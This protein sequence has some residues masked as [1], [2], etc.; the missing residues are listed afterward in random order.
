MSKSKPSKKLLSVALVAT[1]LVVFWFA[2]SPVRSGNAKD[3]ATKAA[4]VH[5]SDP[6]K[7][8]GMM[9]VAMTLKPS[10]DIAVQLAEWQLEG[11]DPDGALTSLKKVSSQSD[12]YWFTRAKVLIDLGQ[13]DAAQAILL[14]RKGEDFK[15]LQAITKSPASLVKAKNL[16]NLH[17]YHAAEK[18]LNESKLNT[19]GTILL[20]EIRLKLGKDLDDLIVKLKEAIANDPSDIR[21]HELLGEVYK[22]QGNQK[23]ASEEATKAQKLRNGKP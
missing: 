16:A 18:V 4:Q 12:R 20:A 14:L 10:E 7:A 21:L 5:D 15:Q 22:K 6:Q 1:G 17:L 23:A 2:L 9:Q 8:I 19:S 11:S 3:L 13:D